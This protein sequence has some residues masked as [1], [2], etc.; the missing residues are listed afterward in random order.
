M[1]RDLEVDDEPFR[2]DGD[3]IV[4]TVG[5]G[6]WSCDGEDTVVTS[7]MSRE[8]ALVQLGY[9]RA[10]L[11]R[12]I[13]H[14]TQ[15]W[16]D[17][18]ISEVSREHEQNPDPTSRWISRD[19]VEV[20][21]FKCDQLRTYR[22]DNEVVRCRVST[23]GWD[24]HPGERRHWTRYCELPRFHDGPHETDHVVFG[25]VE[26]VEFGPPRPGDVRRVMRADG[27]TWG[28]TMHALF[29]ARPEEPE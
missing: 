1:I 7:R 27:R 19:K 29:T 17:H 6:C 28:E 12:A 24:D 13:T 25:Y 21:C 20:A 22:F 14:V 26:K 4:W 16:C 8:K 5:E 2:V 10:S 9:I 18:E 15:N 23:H 3:R 11:D